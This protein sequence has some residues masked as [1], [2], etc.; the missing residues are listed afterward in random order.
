MEPQ[1]IGQLILHIA[2]Y[3]SFTEQQTKHLE[4][5]LMYPE[6]DIVSTAGTRR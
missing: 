3:R 4:T 6:M 2:R 1:R 5:S